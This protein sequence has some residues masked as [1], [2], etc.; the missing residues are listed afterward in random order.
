M[1]RIKNVKKC[2]LRCRLKVGLSLSVSLCAVFCFICHNYGPLLSKVNKWMKMFSAFS[3]TV[4]SWFWFSL[5]AFVYSIHY[6]WSSLLISSPSSSSS[7][8]SSSSGGR[9]CICLLS[10]CS[11][12]SFAFV[13]C[14][15]ADSRGT[16]S[17]PPPKPRKGKNKG[18]YVG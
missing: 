11:W 5:V 1:A 9:G 15:G 16:K 4:L 8:S 10:P 17:R 14:V 18:R 12:Y 2:V 3:C 13:T 6:K 7:S